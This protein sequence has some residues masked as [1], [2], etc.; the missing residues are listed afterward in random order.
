MDF[1]P[2]WIRACGLFLGTKVH[3]S[4]PEAPIYPDLSRAANLTLH[5]RTIGIIVCVVPS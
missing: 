1:F 4:H 3:K 5:L 2:G